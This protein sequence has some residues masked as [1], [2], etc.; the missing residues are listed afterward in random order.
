MFFKMGI[1][2]L[3]SHKI[4]KVSVFDLVGTFVV[5]FI[6]D[7][8]FKIHS[9]LPGSRPG[10]LYYLLLI[11]LAVLVHVSVGQKTFLNTKIFS[12]ELNFYQIAFVLNLYLILV[13]ST[14]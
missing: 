1:T 9:R 8:I 14:V 12:N 3:R 6:L 10:T 4:F 2:E 5:A 7:K 13:F 11:P